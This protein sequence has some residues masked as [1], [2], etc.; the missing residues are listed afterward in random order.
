M[1]TISRISVASLVALSVALAGNVQAA[2]STPDHL[3]CFQIKDELSRRTI[4]TAELS[5]QQNSPFGDQNCKIKIPA[6][7]LCVDTAKTNVQ[8]PDGTEFATLPIGG[9]ATRDYLCYHLHCDKEDVVLEASDQ[10]GH[11]TV[12]TKKSDFF[13]APAEQVTDD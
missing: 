9:T 1:T 11:R 6:S 5:P 2:E 10:F 12:R 3:K 7:H 13:C 4:Y 8:N